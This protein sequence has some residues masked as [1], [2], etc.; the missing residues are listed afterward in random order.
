AAAART[1]DARRSGAG[2][3]APSL[4]SDR[5][6]GLDRYSELGQS[7]AWQ[8]RS[9]RIAGTALTRCSSRL[10][11]E[12]RGAIQPPRKRRRSRCSKCSIV[13]ATAP[14]GPPVENVTVCT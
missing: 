8:E 12:N 3:C 9:K 1:A 13:I 10:L 2:P 5:G 6:N 14:A 7:A 4:R 11:G